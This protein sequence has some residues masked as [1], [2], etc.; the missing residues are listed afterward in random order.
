MSSGHTPEA[1]VLG[2]S[3]HVLDQLLADPRINQRLNMPH[4]LDRTYD[5]PYLGGYSADGR[6]IYLDKD[7]PIRVQTKDGRSFDPT[8]FLENHEKIEKAIIDVLGWH[9]LQAHEAATNFERRTVMQAGLDWHTY[10]DAIEGWVTKVEHFP[11]QRVPADLDMTPYL[12]E[13]DPKTLAL[14]KQAMV[15]LQQPQQPPMAGPPQ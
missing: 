15:P 4:H 12:A 10:N 3:A 7:F 8:P 14:M 2:H 6:T 11:I 5:I 1:R 9:Y 13:A